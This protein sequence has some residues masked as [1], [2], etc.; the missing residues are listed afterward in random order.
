[1]LWFP[2]KLYYSA[3]P[4]RVGFTA[5]RTDYPQVVDAPNADYECPPKTMKP[6]GPLN[7]KTS[8]NFTMR[9][10]SLRRTDL[11]P[12]DAKYIEHH[13]E[14]NS[15]DE[16]DLEAQPARDNLPLL[17]PSPLSTQPPEHQVTHENDLRL[18]IFPWLE[19]SSVQTQRPIHLQSGPMTFHHPRPVRLIRFDL[20]SMFSA[21]EKAVP[22]ELHDKH[23]QYASPTYSDFLR[24]EKE[25][26]ERI[27]SKSNYRPLS[28]SSDWSSKQIQDTS[29]G[30][31]PS[32]DGQRHRLTVTE[33]SPD[34]SIPFH[35]GGIGS[36]QGA[37]FD[38]PGN[39]RPDSQPP[40]T[41]Q[42]PEEKLTQPPAPQQ[43]EHSVDMS[44]SPPTELPTSYD[45]LD[46]LQLVNGVFRRTD[47]GPHLDDVRDALRLAQ[48]CL[49]E[50]GE[51]PRDMW[52][53]QYDTWS[54]LYRRRMESLISCVRL[55]SGMLWEEDIG[56]AHEIHFIAEEVH[57]ITINLRA[58]FNRLR[59]YY[60]RKQKMIWATGAKQ[61]LS[62]FYARQ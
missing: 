32:M 35:H 62:S 43:R 25:I 41:F 24:L 57:D 53:E 16:F 3:R 47:S 30:V 27:T 34:D 40:Q 61:V 29:N 8:Q 17:T 2:R 33:G 7:I 36:D 58:S 38:R 50:Q 19:K 31:T 46:C 10:S 22:P 45:A 42:T 20:M 52:K 1:M 9:H 55:I 11:D 15:E 56:A 4:A 48:V 39:A 23:P 54:T 28:E 51:I 18:S 14:G 49:R 26:E 59:E 37:C 12:G 60:L 44:N 5:H 6:L 21:M 13:V